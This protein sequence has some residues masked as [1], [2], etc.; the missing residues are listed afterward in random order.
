[1]HQ[2]MLSDVAKASRA[3]FNHVML[4]TINS[5]LLQKLAAAAPSAFAKQQRQHSPPSPLGGYI[6]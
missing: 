6:P 1:M 2:T 3:G 4:Q 5:S